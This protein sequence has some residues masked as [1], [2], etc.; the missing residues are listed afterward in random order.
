[1]YAIRKTNF[2]NISVMSKVNIQFFKTL[3]TKFY[4]KKIK[5]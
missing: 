2:V 4:N 3:L 5:N 1:M